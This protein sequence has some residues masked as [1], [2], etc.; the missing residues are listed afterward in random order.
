MFARRRGAASMTLASI[1]GALNDSA[2]NLT[3]F[4]IDGRPLTEIEGEGGK[5]AGSGG[6]L[7]L[8]LPGYGRIDHGTK[9]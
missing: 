8:V 5:N 6:R 1:D 2:G 7:L 4:L 9:Q 3:Q